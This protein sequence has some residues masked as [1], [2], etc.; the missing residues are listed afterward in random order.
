MPDADDGVVES[1]GLV[2]GEGS[3]PGVA[4]LLDCSLT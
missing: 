1:D 3:G 2:P 4:K